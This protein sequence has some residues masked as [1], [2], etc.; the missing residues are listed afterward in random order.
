MT[1]DVVTPTI[2]LWFSPLCDV[3]LSRLLAWEACYTEIP[4]YLIKLPLLKQRTRVSFRVKVELISTRK[5]MD[6]IKGVVDRPTAFVHWIPWTQIELD[7]LVR[8]VSALRPK[9]PIE[10]IVVRMR[11]IWTKQPGVMLSGGYRVLELAS[12]QEAIK[13]MIQILLEAKNGTATQKLS[14]TQKHQASQGKDLFE[15]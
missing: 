3:V 13:T 15:V 6:G 11:E 2:P 9:S 14:E 12:Y 1:K 7:H 4:G 5:F 8:I 10:E